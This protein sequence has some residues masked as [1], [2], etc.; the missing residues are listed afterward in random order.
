MQLMVA[1]V[2]P[3]TLKLLVVFDLEI[4]NA[5]ILQKMLLSLNI[6]MGLGDLDVLAVVLLQ[7]NQ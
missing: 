2:P 5:V 3:L 1:L 7:W 4:H 6:M